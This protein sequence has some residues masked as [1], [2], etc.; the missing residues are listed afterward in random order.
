[1]KSRQPVHFIFTLLALVFSAW[2]CSHSLVAQT[3]P[4]PPA[5]EE[6]VPPA[7]KKKP[8]KPVVVPPH[9]FVRC[10]N[11]L[12]HTSGPIRVMAGGSVVFNFIKP[13]IVGT[14]IPVPLKITSLEFQTADGSKTLGKFDVKADHKSFFTLVAVS[15][16]GK[17]VIQRYDDKAGAPIKKGDDA[18]A[19]PPADETCRLRVISAAL[20]Y[21]IEI[22]TPT[23][24]K[25]GP[26][27]TL[28]VHEWS[29]DPS[30][31]ETLEISYAHE[32]G[33]R[34]P[35]TRV[36]DWTVSK[37]QTLFVGPY[38]PT[39]VQAVLQPDAIWNS[40]MTDEELAEALKAYDTH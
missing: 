24:K 29:C 1:M 3:P 10:A 18:P 25:L 30:R 28:T 12:P 11:M 40:E 17:A 9:Y 20:N 16:N 19:E 6:E 32:S 15:E 7:E 8:T 23:G 36:T 35:T 14:Y 5:P 37:K 31:P 13:G 33:I 26:L 21:K 38:G 4:P 34:V 22:K 2:L 27:D 39:R